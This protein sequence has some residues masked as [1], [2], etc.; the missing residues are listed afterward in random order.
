MDAGSNAPNYD[1][2]QN[3]GGNDGA[4]NIIVDGKR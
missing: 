4:L 2:Q 1:V 3:N